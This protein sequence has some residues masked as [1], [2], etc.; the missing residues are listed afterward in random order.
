MSLGDLHVSCCTGVPIVNFQEPMLYS[1][2]E[3]KVIFPS[4]FNLHVIGRQTNFFGQMATENDG[5]PV[6]DITQS[7]SDEG[8]EFLQLC[9]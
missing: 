7:L 9:M 6:V 8:L 2:S 4:F 5:L 1:A 3:S